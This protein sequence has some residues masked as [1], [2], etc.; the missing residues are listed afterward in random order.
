ME[1]G[2]VILPVTIA[3][4]AHTGHPCPHAVREATG[5]CHEC[6]SGQRHQMRIFEPVETSRGESEPF[7]S[8]SHYAA[9]SG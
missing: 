6:P 9:T 2:K 7:F 1:V 3:L 4:P 8:R 5:D